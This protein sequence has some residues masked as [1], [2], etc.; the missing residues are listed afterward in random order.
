M[1]ELNRIHDSFG[2]ALG[3]ANQCHLTACQFLS[4]LILAFDPG[5][6]ALILRKYK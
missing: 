2:K 1:F 6:N 4:I 3:T 5:F